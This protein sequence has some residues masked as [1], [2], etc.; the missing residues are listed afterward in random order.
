MVNHFECS[1]ESFSF[2]ATGI[3]SVPSLDV[4]QTCLQILDHCPQIPFWPQF[5]KRTHLEDMTLQ[6][7]E[8]LPSLTVD[9]KDRRPVL[10]EQ[11]R[12]ADL[13]TFYE[14]ILAEELDPF[15]LSRD[16]ASGLY[17]LLALLQKHPER[18]GPY[19]K[20][21][22]IGPVTFCLAVLDPEGK[23][24][25]HDPEWVEAMS[26][27][28]AAK[29]LWQVRELTRSGKRPL[30]FLDEPSL[31]GFGSAFSPIQREEVIRLLTEF[32]VYLRERSTVCIGIHCCGNTDWSMILQARPDIVSFDAF[33]YLDYFLLY[34]DE[35]LR[36]LHRGGSI[37]WGIVPTAEDV[38]RV[39]AETLLNKIRQ[40]LDQLYA[41]GVDRETIRNRSLLTPACG[42]ANME[43]GSAA[44]ALA[45]LKHLSA[46]CAEER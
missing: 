11:N 40:G 26:R 1:N 37:A 3:G 24:I 18:Y 36:Y 43:V 20:G 46:L 2:L 41:W 44:R 29:A 35:L 13:A 38:D 22:T 33:G 16:H 34:R 27:G 14:H 9:Q 17:E 19:V 12:A 30:L 45:L 21:Q 25:I 6:F 4:E 10:S 39:A 23:A 28:L 8:G 5:P 42:M 7:I 32:M 15:A 31:S